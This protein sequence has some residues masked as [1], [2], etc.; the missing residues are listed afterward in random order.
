MRVYLDNAS[1]TPLLPEVIEEMYTTMKEHFGNP[2][3]IHMHGRKSR[4]IL[5]NSRKVLA[6]YLN[7][8][9]GEVFFTSCATEANNLVLTKCV[10]DL[11]VTTIIYSSIEHHC[12]F[13]MVEHLASQH[14]IEAIK[15][16]VDN[17]G[18]LDY[19]SLEKAIE[20]AGDKTL[21]SIMHGNNEIGVLND[22]KHIGEICRKHGVLFH[23]DTVQTIGKYNIDT[24]DI[25]IHF[26]AGSAHKFFGPKGIG[27]VYINDDVEISPMLLGGS[28]E[29]NMRS[30]TEN[31]Y[32]IAGMSKALD[33]AMRDQEERKIQI[34]K[35]K[36]HFISRITTELDDI[37]IN[38][39]LDGMYHVLS[40]SFPPTP[41][42]ELLMFNLDIAGISAS[43]GSACSSGVEEDSHVLQ[44]IGHDRLR[45]TIRFS[46]SHF[47]TIEEVDYT[48]DKLKVLTPTVAQ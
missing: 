20:M 15:I 22:I 24:Q 41:K 40:V 8:S 42:A 32:G 17:T 26:A 11:G 14:G 37:K 1:T 27:F 21:V 23:S 43:S 4:S 29:R 6:K 45:K 33:I 31:V 36:N 19:Q 18:K 30:G 48:I 5:E 46:F 2:S 3:S 39:N 16:N 7:A 28:Q 35:I 13:H 12:I 34:L 44:A 10:E 38:G 47:N 25:N 9:L